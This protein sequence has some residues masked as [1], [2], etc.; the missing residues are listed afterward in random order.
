LAYVACGAVLWNFLARPWEE[1]DLEFQFGEHYRAY[2]RAV[3]CWLPRLRPYAP[4]Q[5]SEEVAIKGQSVE[6]EERP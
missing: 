1:R 6:D 2:K 4:I 5:K 3:R